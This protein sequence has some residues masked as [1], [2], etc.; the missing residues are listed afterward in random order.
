[1]LRRRRGEAQTEY[2]I[3]VGLISICV[4]VGMFRFGGKIQEF[5]EKAN[6]C[7]NCDD[8]GG[9]Q[10][11][12]SSKKAKPPPKKPT[13]EKPPWYDDPSSV[14]YWF[15]QLIRF[16]GGAPHVYDLFS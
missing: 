3:I 9:Q 6:I 8:A 11:G 7:V 4:V 15:F 1:M 10:D 14:L 12:A 5:L 13:G 2:V 16:F